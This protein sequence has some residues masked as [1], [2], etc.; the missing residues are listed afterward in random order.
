MAQAAATASLGADGLLRE[1]VEALVAERRR[2]VQ[3]LRRAGWQPV[4]GEGN[5]IWLRLGEAS[6]AF[7]DRCARGGVL[8]R[9]YP[10]DGVRVTIGLPAENDRFLAVAGRGS[11]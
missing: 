6:R 4:E 8:V 3:A 11:R 1:R 10:G 5:F 2:V 9:P 7:A